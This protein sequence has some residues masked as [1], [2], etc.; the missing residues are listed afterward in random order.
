MVIPLLESTEILLVWKMNAFIAAASGH[1]LIV[2]GM[3]M[4][5]QIG[6][7]CLVYENLVKLIRV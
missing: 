1:A 5:G 7:T 6:T 4:P 2:V 3:K